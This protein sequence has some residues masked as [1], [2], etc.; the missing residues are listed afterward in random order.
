MTSGTTHPASVRHVSFATAGHLDDVGNALL[1]AAD[2]LLAT[3]GAAALTVRRI[4]AEA[5]MSTMNV[6]SRF[7]GKDGVV[8]QLFLHG[9][10]LLAQGMRAVDDSDDPIADLRRCGQAYRRFAIEHSTLYAVM[11]DRVVA[12][13]EP[14]PP[15]L[16]AALGTLELLAARLQRAM[17][18]GLVRQMDATHAAAIVWSTCHGVV[19]LELKHATINPVD[20]Q[21]VYADATEAVVRGLAS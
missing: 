1:R 4:A 20:W 16:A 12:D 2:G 21:Q 19:S 13:Y 3:E 9:F 18:F 8:E 15:A 17:H 10:E 5:G 14:S 11:F 7:G 6:N